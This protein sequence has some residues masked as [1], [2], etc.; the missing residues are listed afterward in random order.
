M[1]NEKCFFFYYSLFEF[2][3]ESFVLCGCSF[4]DGSDDV[5]VFVKGNI[6]EVPWCANK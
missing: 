4:F 2:K 1:I 6:A 5:E 3:T